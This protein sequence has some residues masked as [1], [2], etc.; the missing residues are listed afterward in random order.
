[1]ERLLIMNNVFLV[2][3]CF[4]LFLMGVFQ[5]VLILKFLI[6]HK[7]NRT[8]NGSISL[9]EVRNVMDHRRKEWKPPDKIKVLLIVRAKTPDTLGAIALHVL[10]GPHPFF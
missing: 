5:F 9:P 1:M 2:C 3:L 6:L 7:R 10:R 8:L 4:C